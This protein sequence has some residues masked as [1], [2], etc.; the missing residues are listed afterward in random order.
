MPARSS[1]AGR[2]ASS[3]VLRAEDIDIAVCSKAKL[4]SVIVCHRTVAR[5]CHTRSQNGCCRLRKMYRHHMRIDAHTADLQAALLDY[6]LLLDLDPASLD[7]LLERAMVYH[8][9]KD[10]EVQPPCLSSC[11]HSCVTGKFH[12]VV[13]EH[14]LCAACIAA[15]RPSC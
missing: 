7:D 6:N 10:H 14:L 9:S 11:R 3:V 13:T 12:L 8:F 5:S 2:W 15:S 4:A 1:D